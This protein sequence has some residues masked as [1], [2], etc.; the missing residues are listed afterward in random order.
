MKNCAMFAAPFSVAKQKIRDT[1][2][3]FFTFGRTYKSNVNPFLKRLIHSNRT[4]SY[5]EVMIENACN[6]YWTI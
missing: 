4:V 1:T 5:R 3:Q 6:M 2:Q